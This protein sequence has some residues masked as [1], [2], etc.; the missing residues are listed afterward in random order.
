MKRVDILAHFTDFGYTPERKRLN[1]FGAL[2]YYRTF[3]PAKQIKNAHVVIEGTEIASHADTFVDNWQDIFASN[4]I[5]WIM[6]YLSE[7]NAAAQSFMRDRF[8]NKLVYDIDDNYLDVPESNPVYGE[9]K[10]GKRNRSLLSTT[11]YFADA[12][13]CSTEPLKERLQKHFKDVHGKDMPI[14]IVP[15]MNDINDWNFIPAPKYKDRIVIGY[16]GSNSHQDDLLMVMP[17]INKL[18]FKY[19]N[20]WFELIGAIDKKKLD[21]YFKN[22]ETKHLERVAMLPSTPTFWEYPPYLAQQKWDISIAPL[23]DS[24]FTRSKSHIK[25][26][27]YSMYKMPT[28]ASRVY[29]YFMD[30][31]G[32]KTITDGETGF[33]C[34][35][36]AEWEKKLEKLILN[37]ELRERIGQQAYDHVKDNWQ[38]SS[39]DFDEVFSRIL[40]LP[41]Q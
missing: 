6:H 9:F 1:T 28:V 31:C 7:Q 8:Q 17:V 21:V 38:Y 22:W 26:L 19:P 36:P 12:L 27:E 24:A 15:N 11:F 33:L 41:K 37:K 25:W 34:R 4:D 23:V 3:K 40:E 39:F 29:P 10:K 18:M 32:R 20:L 35:T 13:T 2:G 5:V 16:S 30:L 14:F